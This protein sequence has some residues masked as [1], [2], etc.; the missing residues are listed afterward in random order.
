MKSIL[1]IH[2]GKGIGGASLC[3]KE[4]LD[5]FKYEYEITVLCIFQSDAVEYFKK[6]G[7]NTVVLNS[8]FYR[9]IYR[10]FYHSEAYSYTLLKPIPSEFV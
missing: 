9:K 5:E 3:L 10:F 8:F 4:L 7:Y 2:Q 1:F 6:S